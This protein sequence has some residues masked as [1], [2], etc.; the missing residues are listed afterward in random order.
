[1]LYPRPRNVDTYDRLMREMGDLLKHQHTLLF[2]VLFLFSTTTLALN[3]NDPNLAREGAQR[4]QDPVSAT[5]EL[6]SQVMGFDKSAPAPQPITSDYSE[7]KTPSLT[8][9]TTDTSTSTTGSGD[10]VAQ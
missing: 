6:F 7:K 8:Q 9:V 4:P 1:M 3:P 5:V 2:S 10:D